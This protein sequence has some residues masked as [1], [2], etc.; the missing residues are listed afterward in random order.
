MA[1]EQLSQE[2]PILPAEPSPPPDKPSN[3]PF[4]IAVGVLGSLIVFGLVV[5]AAFFLFFAPRKAQERA[6]ETQQ[7]HLASQKIQQQT[8]VANAVTLTSA[9]I[10]SMPTAT[11]TPAPATNTPV[12]VVATNTATPTS[13]P[14]TATVAALLT[15]AAQ[16]QLTS[17]PDA[18]AAAGAA[19][20]TQAAA[21]S[22]TQV[23]GKAQ[24]P[25]DTL[26]KAG[27]A[28]E[29]GLPGMLIL[30]AALAALTFFARRLRTVLK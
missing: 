16:A 14:H 11:V 18:S 29:V 12:V 8:A 13:D 25:S 3:R 15:Q 27:F 30:A 4:L 6:Q 19:N 7:F 2:E 22:P 20:T 23:I 24:N 5:L 28:D 10:M 26:P 17:T 1:F 9:A 21:G